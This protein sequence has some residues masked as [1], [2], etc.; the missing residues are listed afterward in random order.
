MSEN[1]TISIDRPIT[2]AKI[3]GV[4]PGEIGSELSASGSV[5]SPTNAEQPQTQNGSV[6]AE[7]EQILSQQLE[8]EKTSLAQTRQALQEIVNKLNQFYDKAFAE[9]Y[10]DI[11]KLSVEIAGKILMQKVDKGDYEIE[12]IVKEA[13]KNS[14]S[15]QDLVLHLNPEDLAKCQKLQQEDDSGG[16]AG[17][18]LV[19]DANIGRAQ[20]VLESPKGIIES[21]IDKNLE[22]IS[23]AL[24]KAK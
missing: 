16:L 4:H 12:P 13:L 24:K 21:L 23:E 18:K 22:Q 14:P 10:E 7:T 2:S 8:T 5:S 9:H 15:H 20:C 17:V 1:L 19:A 11:A 3:L 6:S